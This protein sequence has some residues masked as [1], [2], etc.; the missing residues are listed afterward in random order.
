LRDIRKPIVLSPGHLHSLAQCL[1]D[2]TDT[3]QHLHRWGLRWMVQ[4]ARQRPGDVHERAVQTRKH[5]NSRLARAHVGHTP[6]RNS[7]FCSGS[8]SLRLSFVTHLRYN[9]PDRLFPFPHRL[10]HATSA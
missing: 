5:A 3:C 8:W 7:S 1:L 10:L 6:I 9:E 2:L 4:A